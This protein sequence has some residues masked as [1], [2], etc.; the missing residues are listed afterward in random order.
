[1]T[2]LFLRPPS[3]LFSFESPAP[4]RLHFLARHHPR[5]GENPS[6]A[7]ER[8]GSPE[9]R[10]Q[11]MLQEENYFSRKFLKEKWSLSP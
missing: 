1:M 5:G 9:L 3:I 11:H 2:F 10:A 6:H 4:L 7:A 8:S